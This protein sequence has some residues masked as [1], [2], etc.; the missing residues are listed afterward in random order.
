ML[1]IARSDTGNLK[2]S[3]AMFDMRSKWLPHET[4]SAPS[5]CGFQNDGFLYRREEKLFFFNGSKGTEFK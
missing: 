1:G 4:F 2:V 3:G 5:L